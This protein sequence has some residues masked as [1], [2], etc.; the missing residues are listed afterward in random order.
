MNE[1]PKRF[2]IDDFLDEVKAHR[3]DRGYLARLKR[4]LAEG[5]EDQSWGILAVQHFDFSNAVKRKVWATV[6]SLA[7]TLM[8]AGLFKTEGWEN[9][10]MVMR[11]IMNADGKADESRV[12]TYETKL[13]RLLNC[14]STV[15]L[16]DLV[17]GVVRQA[18]AKG[19]TV[20]CRQLYF[21]LNGW[22]DQEKREKSRVRWAQDFYRVE[23]EQ[24]GQMSGFKG[25]GDAE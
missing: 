13:R 7:A 8:D 6:G 9:M 16:C 1:E 24:D 22:D 20:N 5:T 25:K 2:A 14:T 15:E 17:I 10:G 18:A 23:R 21:D 4:G 11:H 12:R 19:V 3:D